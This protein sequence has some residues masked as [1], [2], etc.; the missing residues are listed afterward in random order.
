MYLYSRTHM[1]PASSL[2]LSVMLESRTS[3]AVANESH[4]ANALVSEL[5]KI[6][7]AAGFVGA[8]V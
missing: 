2:V 1:A 3:A 7:W 5:G 4:S 8:E 6:L